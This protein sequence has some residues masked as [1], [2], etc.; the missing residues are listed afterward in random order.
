MQPKRSDATESIR[1]RNC[2]VGVLPIA[3]HT[4][5]NTVGGVSFARRRKRNALLNTRNAF[6]D[7]NN[8]STSNAKK[9]NIIELQYVLVFCVDEWCMRAHLKYHTIYG[10]VGHC[11]GL[12]A[13]V[14]N[15]C[16]GA[17]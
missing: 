6:G 17:I 15:M 16:V 10:T 2:S 9:T 8:D 12:S 4:I 13:G 1:R 14:F 11:V 3:S 7:A 5:K